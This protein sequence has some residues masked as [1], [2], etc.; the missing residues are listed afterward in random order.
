MPG[1]PPMSSAEPGTRPPPVTRSNSPMPETLRGSF[2]ESSPLRPVSGR[3]LPFFAPMPL[4][5][6][7]SITSSAIE[8]HSLQDSHF[9]AHL[10]DT[11]PQDWQ[12]YVRVGLAM[13]IYLARD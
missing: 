12:T 7:A 6:A 1:S 5:M 4:G 3:P 9:P 13:M 10:E 11:A 2:V 8:F